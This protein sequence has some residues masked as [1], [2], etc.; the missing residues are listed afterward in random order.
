MFKI[1]WTAWESNNNI[2]TSLDIQDLNLIKTIKHHKLSYFGH[3]NK[4]NTRRY[5]RWQNKKWKRTARRRWSQDITEQMGTSAT[6][7]EITAHDIKKLSGYSE[8]GNVH[9]D[10][11]SEKKYHTEILFIFWIN[12]RYVSPTVLPHITLKT[13]I[14]KWQWETTKEIRKMLEQPLRLLGYK[15]QRVNDDK[16]A[17]HICVTW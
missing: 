17:I 12:K 14:L 7:S 8:G 3:N 2:M 15:R 5:G 13:Q 1:P 16:I 4:Q 11:L 9:R 6:K 10:I